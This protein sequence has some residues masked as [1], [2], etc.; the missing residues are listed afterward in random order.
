MRLTKGGFARTVG[1]YLAEIHLKQVDGVGS[2][3]DSS[4]YRHFTFHEYQNTDLSK[5]V[6]SLEKM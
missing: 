2:I 3:P 6:A 1:D 5:R 4:N